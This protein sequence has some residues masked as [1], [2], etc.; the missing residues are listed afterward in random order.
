MGINLK[1]GGVM[2]FKVGDFVMVR[3]SRSIPAR[4]LGRFGLVS[5][6]KDDKCIV[7][8]QFRMN[9]KGSISCSVLQCELSEVAHGEN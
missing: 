7:L 3:G 2:S 8:F 5:D 1:I 6:I 4:F 9:G